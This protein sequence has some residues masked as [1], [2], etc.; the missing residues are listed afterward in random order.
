MISSETNKKVKV[1][2]IISGT[3][4]RRVISI[5]ASS[6]CPPSSTG[7]GI[8]LKM[9]RAKEIITKKYMPSKNDP[10]YT[11][12]KMVRP[13]P[14]GPLRLLNFNVLPSWVRPAF[15]ETP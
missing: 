12:M 13:R 4:R 3:G 11:E 7:N 6:I 2:T 1:F 14:I 15:W 10:Y 8:R 5:P 9:A